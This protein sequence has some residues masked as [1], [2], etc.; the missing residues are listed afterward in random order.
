MKNI[1]IGL[2][3][4]IHRFKK[5]NK[6]VVGGVGIPYKLGLVGHSDA[7]VL[8]HAICDALLGAAGKPDIGEHFPD[9]D[10]KYKNILSS[11]L[12]MEVN[13]IISKDKFKIV[14]IDCIVITDNPKINP[15]SSKIKTNISRMLKIK[16][17]CIGIKAKTTEGILSYSNKGIAAYC[18]ALLKH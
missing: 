11:K 18:V 14:N 1:R 17:S 13:R 6:L 3:F 5:G 4:D 12:L 15:Y 10:K 16:E 2:G 7:D 9:T 8:L